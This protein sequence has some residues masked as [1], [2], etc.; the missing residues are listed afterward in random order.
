MV[1]S[2]VFK[3]VAVSVRAPALAPIFRSD[4]QFR[5]LGYLAVGE[6]R[7]ATVTDIAKAIG[8][9]YAAVWAEIDRLVKAGVLTQLR[10]GRSKVVRL[11]ESSP[12]IEP[13]RKLLLMSYGPL[14]LLRERL[15]SVEIVRDAF[16][17]GS[18]ARRYAGEQGPPPRDVDVLA[19]VDA[20][21]AA[22]VVYQA[23]G[24]AGDESGRTV[25]ATVL[26]SGEWESDR[27]SFASSVRQQPRVGILGD[28][29]GKVF[30]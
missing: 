7:Q 8:A 17:Y 16:I 23:C 20:G 14:P 22:A 15:E 28:D 25:N 4:L 1:L 19:I 3:G 24:M 12:Y 11:S 10:I 27:S 5:M 13:L 29:F 30:T 18:W 26:T 21:A 6:D 9:S 2:D